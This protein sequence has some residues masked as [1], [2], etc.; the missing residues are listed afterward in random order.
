M[1]TIDNF[2][3]TDRLIETYNRTGSAM[4]IEEAMKKINQDKNSMNAKLNEAI[5]DREDLKLIMEI[6]RENN[7][8]QGRCIETLEQLKEN[9]S[10]TIE[11]AVKNGNMDRYVYMDKMAELGPKYENRKEKLGIIFQDVLARA[12]KGETAGWKQI[13]KEY[14]GENQNKIDKLEK[15]KIE[16]DNKYNGVSENEI[17]TEVS[18]QTIENEVKEMYN[19]IMD[20]ESQRSQMLQNSQMREEYSDNIKDL[21]ENIEKLTLKKDEYNKF[22][23][24]NIIQQKSK[25]DV[26]VTEKKSLWKKIVEKVKGIF[27]KPQPMLEAPKEV[28]EAGPTFEEVVANSKDAEKEFMENFKSSLKVNDY[29]EPTANKPK[30]QLTIHR[31][32]EEKEQDDN[33]NI[34]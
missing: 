10:K 3:K 33:E 13:E 6:I 12:S 20:E 26:K 4:S 32:K 15:N 17:I 8:N 18:K 24:E 1:K 34:I 29:K 2:N 25:D 11:E 7:G 22:L 31:K 21:R 30:I 14:L 27:K 16:L 19:E 5:A 28:K 23:N 9:E